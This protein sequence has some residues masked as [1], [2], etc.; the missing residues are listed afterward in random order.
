M[1]LV[2]WRRSSPWAG[3]AL[4]LLAPQ[5]GLA[6]DDAKAP[7]AVDASRAFQGQVIYQRYCG[8]CHGPQGKGDGQIASGLRT[9]PTD[10]TR[11]AARNKNVFP[12]EKVARAIDGRDTV[13]MHGPSDMP[14]WGE[15]FGKTQGTE[16]ADTQ[17]AV[18]RI[19]HYVWSIQPKPE[20]R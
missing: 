17:E 18:A 4:A 19:T 16:A 2:D 1:R 8:A 20:E 13:R 15:V 5:V 14:V 10:L 3:L 9:K 11:L 7:T 12:Y 6:T